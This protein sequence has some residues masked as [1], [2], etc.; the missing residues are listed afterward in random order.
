M[1]ISRILELDVAYWIAGGMAVS[2][3]AYLAKVLMPRKR[4]L[5][6]FHAEAPAPPEKPRPIDL[7][8]PVP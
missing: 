2:G 1:A 5:N 7:N 8:A 6:Q 4:C 3:G